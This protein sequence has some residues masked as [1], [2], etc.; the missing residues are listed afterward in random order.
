MK[1]LLALLLCTV[2]LAA[3]AGLARAA[4][5]LRIVVYGGTGNIGQRIVREALNRGHTV[6]V[7]VRDPSSMTEHSARLYVLKGD[8]LDSAQVARTISGADVVVCAVSFRRPEPDF[9]GY[10]R[11]AEVLIAALRSLGPR[12]PHLIVVGGAGSLERSPGV[13][14]EDSI[15]V[16]YRGEVH[17]QKVA[18]D[19]YRTVTDVPWT[20]LSPAETIRPGTRTGHFRLGGDRL[21]TDATGKSRIS[22]EDYAVAVIDEAEKPAHIQQRFTIG[23]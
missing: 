2:V 11:A 23:Y 12:A 17:G 20:Y 16:A 8:V 5:P 22:M 9:G 18:L 14:V 6:T 10:R 4:H 21:V 7:V 19:Y 1:R 15:P 13:L 3:S